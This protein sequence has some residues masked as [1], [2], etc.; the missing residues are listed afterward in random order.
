MGTFKSAFNAVVDAERN[1]IAANHADDVKKA[2]NVVK[3]AQNGKFEGTGLISDVE[4]A[5]GD[6]MNIATFGTSRKITNAFAKK[7]NKLAY[8]DL[9]AKNKEIKQNDGIKLTTDQRAAMLAGI[10]P[11]ETQVPSADTEVQAE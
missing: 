11:E 8:K 3:D 9:K 1:A 7:E 5:I 4:D 10:V 6:T 2:H